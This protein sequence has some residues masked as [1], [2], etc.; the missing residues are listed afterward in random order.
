MAP[1]RLADR[2]DSLLSREAGPALPDPGR[3]ARVGGGRTNPEP[4]R[5]IT[6][7]FYVGYLSRSAGREGIEAALRRVR[8]VHEAEVDLAEQKATVSLNPDE[9]RLFDLM[10]ALRRAGGQVRGGRT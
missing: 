8:G 6:V 3:A 7:S 5:S 2:S 1:S 10:S 4:G 9:V